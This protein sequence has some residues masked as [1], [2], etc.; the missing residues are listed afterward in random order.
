MNHK[1]KIVK[2]NPPKYCI[3]SSSDIEN[4]DSE[5]IDIEISEIDKKYGCQII[6]NGTIP[7]LKY[8]LRLISSLDIFVNKYSILIESDSE[9]QIDH[10]IKWNEIL[11]KHFD[12]SYGDQ[13]IGD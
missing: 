1:E 2:Y 13:K 12:I 9:L 6:I 4:S 3:S 10:K 8:Y 5:L 11:S 7:T